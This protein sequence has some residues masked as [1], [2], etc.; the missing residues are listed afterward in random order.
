MNEY[1]TVIFAYLWFGRAGRATRPDTFNVFLLGWVCSKNSIIYGF[2]TSVF[3]D[4]IHRH[5]SL[6]KNL[7]E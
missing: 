7:L 6:D 4:I 2:T 5:L 3:I 1:S